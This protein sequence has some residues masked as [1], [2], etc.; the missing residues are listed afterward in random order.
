MKETNLLTLEHLP[1]GW[2]TP[3]TLSS[4]V[5]DAGI[6]NV[7][8]PLC[9]DNTS[10]NKICGFQLACCLS[11]PWASSPYQ[12]QLSHQ[13]NNSAVRAETSPAC[14]QYSSGCLDKV[15]QTQITLGHSWPTPSSA[16]AV[17]PRHPCAKY[18]ETP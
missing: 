18:P 11:E 14:P 16:P 15:C 4:G 8:F 9:P 1:H 17:L 2:G 10:G 5:G 6:T 12:L 13:G 7:I 3:G